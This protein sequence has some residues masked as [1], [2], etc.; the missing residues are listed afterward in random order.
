[1]RSR[2]FESRRIGDAF[3]YLACCPFS[4]RVDMTIAQACYAFLPGKQHPLSDVSEFRIL[5]HFLR[6]NGTPS[7]TESLS[8]P[9]CL[10]VPGGIPKVPAITLDRFLPGVHVFCREMRFP[11]DYVD[12]LCTRLWLGNQR[13]ERDVHPRVRCRAA[14]YSSN[15]NR[16]CA[17]RPSEIRAARID[18]LRRR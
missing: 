2:R 3:E 11:E 4:H 6:T 18:A 14:L 12:S 16:R 10:L 5:R 17:K 1:M 7:A 13:T 9:E 15:D 8:V